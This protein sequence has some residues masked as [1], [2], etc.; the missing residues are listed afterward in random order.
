MD[1][2]LL[3]FN[4]CLK[5]IC[6]SAY[7]AVSDT[8]INTLIPFHLLLLRSNL[9]AFH[10]PPYYILI[11]APPLEKFHSGTMGASGLNI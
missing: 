5:S 2:S 8:V 3:E 10:L 4:S 11:F 7:Y 9:L 1:E 6:L